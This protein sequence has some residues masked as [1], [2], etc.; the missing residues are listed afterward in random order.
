MQVS[1]RRDVLEL[2]EQ[3]E[4]DAVMRVHDAD[5]LAFRGDPPLPLP[6]FPPASGD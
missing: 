2:A 6:P 5:P 1:S 4:S 3:E